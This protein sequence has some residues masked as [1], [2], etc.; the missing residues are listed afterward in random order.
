MKY[1]YLIIGVIFI[2]CN[3]KSITVDTKRVV[4]PKHVVEEETIIVEE[5][6]IIEEPKITK[7]IKQDI[8]PS[9]AIW[10]DGCNVCTRLSTTK[11]SCTT[12]PACHNRLVSCLQWQ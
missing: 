2:G 11:A 1:L 12:Y 5:K 8:P 6:V 7:N 4:E 10:S 9:C 3:S